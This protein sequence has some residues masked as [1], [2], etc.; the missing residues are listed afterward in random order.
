MAA[1]MRAV[2]AMMFPTGEASPVVVGYN[3]WQ[4]SRA[5]VARMRM[6]DE[7]GAAARER[8]RPAPPLDLGGNMQLGWRK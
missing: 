6:L 1:H 2:S 8:N 5:D 4:D 7:M 3:S